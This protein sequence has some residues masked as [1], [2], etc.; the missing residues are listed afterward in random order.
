MVY[1]NSLCF[2]QMYP[3]ER[4]GGWRTASHHK[5]FPSLHECRE[6]IMSGLTYQ[7]MA[8]DPSLC[9]ESRKNETRFHDTDILTLHETQRVTDAILENIRYDTDYYAFMFV[10]S[11]II[12]GVCGSYFLL[13]HIL[14]CIFIKCVQ[15][16]NRN[17]WGPKD[18]SL[19]EDKLD[20]LTLESKMI[21]YDDYNCK[22]NAINVRVATVWHKAVPSSAT[23][24][25]LPNRSSATEIEMT[26]RTLP[27]SS[28]DRTYPPPRGTPMDYT[29]SV[30]RRVPRMRSE[31]DYYTCM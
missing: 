27:R 28:F 26:E 19:E 21:K 1:C 25:D 10:I 30:D 23:N 7:G 18:A 20:S 13:L 4:G 29:R 11:G 24:G 9:D 3:G 2:L 6:E 8:M 22:P 16:R 15:S 17:N 5:F 14:R 31:K 12:V